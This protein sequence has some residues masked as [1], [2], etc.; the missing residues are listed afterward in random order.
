[1]PK[2]LLLADDSVTIQKVVGITFAN[3]DIE[4]VTVD[5]GTDALAKARQIF[6][7]LV[8]ADIGM[9]GM[10]GY[11]LCAAIRRVPELSHVPVLLLT[12]TFE[13]YDEVRARA[14]GASGHISKP[15]EAQALVD[16]VW[17]L[18]AE[19][20]AA[21]GATRVADPLERMPGA[22]PPV[23]SSP[24]PDPLADLPELPNSSFGA[25]R[26]APPVVPAAPPRLPEPK[27]S[28][29][30]D[31]AATRPPLSPPLEEDDAPLPSPIGRTSAWGASDPLAATVRDPS[32]GETAF[33]D[34]LHDLTPPLP[35]PEPAS[36]AS[37]LPPA[38]APDFLDLGHSVDPQGDT[39]PTYADGSSIASEP[40]E[41]L[42]PEVESGESLAV[43]VPPLAHAAPLV[44]AQELPEIDPLDLEPLEPADPRDTTLRA[45]APA[46]Q[47]SPPPTP[48]APAAAA[49]GSARPL[50]GEALH[51]ALEK[52]AWEAFGSLSQELV[53]QFTRR[54]EA[55]LW[56][57]VPV[58]TERLVREEIA[59][60]K[61]EP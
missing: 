26:A 31:L 11:E 47:A 58:V 25:S 60:L 45:S 10:D 33:L 40:G 43:I 54:V 44:E 52:L 37:L 21:Q 8:L 27:P 56:E 55:I 20:E 22:A 9:P 16:R 53:E 36:R 42:D 49:A 28:D 41:P 6:P 50:D 48:P 57:V 12:G 7:D 2:T 5:N 35:R 23:A 1:M 4:L 15:F 19:A 46:L 51:A 29:L 38:E 39:S 3:E 17:A 30:F 34:P 32:G 61:G 18:L 59:R 14:A 24:A 13:S